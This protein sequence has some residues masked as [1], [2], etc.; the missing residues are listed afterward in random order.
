MA[1]APSI[2]HYTEPGDIVLGGFCGSGMTGVPA[3]WCG[4]APEQYRRELESRCEKQGHPK[5]TWGACRAVLY[6]LSP[7]DTFIVANYNLP[8]DVRE[9]SRAGKHILD[10]ATAILILTEIYPGF[11]MFRQSE[12]GPKNTLCPSTGITRCPSRLPG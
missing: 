5:P 2:L 10:V 4:T 7:E 9:F 12:P 8:F 11:C 1:I 6:D 3:Q